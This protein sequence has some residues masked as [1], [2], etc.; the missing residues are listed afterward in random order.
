MTKLHLTAGILCAGFFLSHTADAQGENVEQFYRGKS[1]DLIIGYAT[2]GS[3]DTYARILASHLGRN[4]SGSPGIV[5]R[6]MPGAGSFLAVNQIYNASARDGSVLGL[7]APT[8]A[9]DEK[10]G[11]NGVRFKTSELNWIGRANSAVNIV[12]TWKTSPVTKIEQA[13]TREVNLGGTGAGSTVSI[14]PNVVNNVVGTRFK[15]IMGYRG[16]SEAMLAMERGETEGHST[17]FEAVKSAHPTWLKDGSVN[18][19]LQFALK[20]H[21][22]MPN[23]PTAL[24]LAKTDDQRQ[25]LS[26][27]L[28][29]TEI[30]ASFFTTPNV[31]EA[32]LAALRRAFGA[33]M[34]DKDFLR[35]AERMRV[36]IQPMSGTDVQKLIKSVS[37]IPTELVQKVRAVYAQGN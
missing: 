18:N 5:V 36:D 14:Y 20:R 19:I 33:T 9:L 37:D 30:G 12:M 24:E 15:L 32:R 17:S 1:I 4:I 34:V 8:I 26:A 7:G 6:N 22:D 21:P 29:A 16:S 11:T 3:N 35:D 27:V 13:F 31:P 10:L 23:V 28:N 2:G 25:I